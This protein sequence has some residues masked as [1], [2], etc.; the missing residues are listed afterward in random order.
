MTTRRHLLALAMLFVAGV[1]CGPPPDEGVVRLWTD[2]FELRVTADVM[3]PRALERITY[4][5]VVRDK[6]TQEPIAHGEGRIFATNADRKTSWNGFT[7]GPEVGTYR[8][9]LTFVTAG[10]WA[11]GIQFRRDST[12]ALQ[13]TLDWRQTVRNEAP[14]G[15]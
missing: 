5:V 11:M 2:D 3:P 4:T 8:A 1:S 10:D 12:Q 13:R 7:Y 15:D 6:K 14:P 9:T